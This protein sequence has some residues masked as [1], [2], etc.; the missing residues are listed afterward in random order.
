MANSRN[1]F[2]DPE[3]RINSALGELLRSFNFLD[4]NLGLCISHLE[5]PGEPQKSHTSLANMST[6]RKVQR[7]HTLIEQGE[8]IASGKRR[9]AYDKW[10]ESTNHCRLIRNFYVHGV[11]EYLP[12][13]SHD[14]LGF[15]VPPWMKHT[16][17]VESE[18]TMS[19]VEF[20]DSVAK[21]TAVYK[22]FMEIRRNNGI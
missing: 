1:K 12:M 15:R 8:Y 14:P 7:L 10:H 6:H 9:S 17:G 4:L 13:R 16:L 11:W 19:L 3:P 21:V 2:L 5:N 20:E 18:K 22:G